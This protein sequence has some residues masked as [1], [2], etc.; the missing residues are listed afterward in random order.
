M[1]E[2]CLICNSANLVKVIDLGMHPF[3]DTFV[4]ESKSDEGDIVYPLVCDLCKECGHVQTRYETDP[5]LRYS[6]VDYSY[7]S[8]N[9][10]FSRAHWEKYAKEV[11]EELKI[12]KGNIIIET[13]SN[14]GYLGEQ[15]IKIG[16]RVFGVD[17]SSYMADL[18]KQRGIE[19]FV[20]LFG[21]EIANRIDKKYG[22]ADIIIANNVFNHSDNPRDFAKAVAMLL[23]PNGSFVFEQPY[24]LIGIKSRSFD[25]IYHEHVSYFT[26]K[27]ASRLL[28]GA[29]MKIKSAKV[30]DYHG[31]S[32]RI[33][34]QKKENIK[35][36]CKEAAEMIE[37]EEKFGLFNIE[38]Y[39]NFMKENFNR[40]S[41]FLQKIHRIKEEGNPI[42]AV[43]AA[44]KGNTFLNFYKL[45]RSIIDFV[46]DA[47]PHKKGKYTPA[48]RIPIVGDEIF[49]KYESPY[50][51]IL[52]WNIAEQLKE[53]LKEYN[54][55]I[56]FISPGELI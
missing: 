47:S 38:T 56:K 49:S 17:P 30:I 46:T 13:G 20:G 22:K 19:T 24:W 23:K 15:F 5:N 3:A 2:R 39:K 45:D 31:G 4:P 29:G 50:A 28:A 8:S 14:D 37:D 34:A 6:Q 12:S 55:N 32:L 40:R 43:G 11:C 41:R 27:S 48:T 52:S 9:S 7:T 44:A 21:N 10:S 25:Q 53:K 42:I 1:R 54:Q 35:D 33:I 18:A 36:E 16:C 26:V 51:L